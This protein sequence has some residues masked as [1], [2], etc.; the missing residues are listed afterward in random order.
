MLPDGTYGKIVPRLGLAL[1]HSIVVGASVIHQDFSGQVGMILFKF[2]SHF[3][4]L[5]SWNYHLLLEFSNAQVV[6]FPHPSAQ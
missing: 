1:K 3:F 2:S 4:Y 6:N 5:S